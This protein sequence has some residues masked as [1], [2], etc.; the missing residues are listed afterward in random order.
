LGAGLV[1]LIVPS[2]RA[3]VTLGAFPLQR[4]LVVLVARTWLSPTGA[5][6]ADDELGRQDGT[7]V[8]A[9]YACLNNQLQCQILIPGLQQ[10]TA[11]GSTGANQFA[12]SRAD[13]RRR[14]AGSRDRLRQRLWLRGD[15]MGM[16]KPQAAIPPWR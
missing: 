16:S 2:L 11:T 3:R 4:L 10:R 15:A 5:G 8:L 12:R 9:G 7:D 14:H 13:T 1:R 6:G